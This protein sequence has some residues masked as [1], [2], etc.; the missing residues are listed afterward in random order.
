M[1]SY[2]GGPRLIGYTAG[3]ADN[4]ASF[5]LTTQQGTGLDLDACDK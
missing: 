5:S 2:P 3:E 1:T 4:G